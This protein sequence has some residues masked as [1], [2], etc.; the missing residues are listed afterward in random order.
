MP[1]EER[2]GVKLKDVNIAMHQI[3]ALPK[4]SNKLMA[5]NYV[6]YVAFLM[7][8]VEYAWGLK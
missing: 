3:Y 1:E 5:S 7:D 8:R 6:G 4:I 2:Y